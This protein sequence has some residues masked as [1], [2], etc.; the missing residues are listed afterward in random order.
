MEYEPRAATVEATRTVHDGMAYVLVTV[1]DQVHC[2]DSAV[3][4]VCFRPHLVFNTALSPGAMAMPTPAE[5]ELPAP[6]PF[7]RRNGSPMREPVE[8]GCAVK[9]GATKRQ[10]TWV[11]GGAVSRPLQARAEDLDS[12]PAALRH[13]LAKTQRAVFCSLKVDGPADLSTLGERLKSE[14]GPVSSALFNMRQKE[15]VIAPAKVGGAWSLV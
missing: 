4:D 12:F 7:V 5:L 14:I 6:E 13:P 10:R 1:N 3:F 2:L 15:L 11:E 8:A 9:Q